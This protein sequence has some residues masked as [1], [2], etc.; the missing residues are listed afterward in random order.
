MRTVVYA[1]ILA[2][3]CYAPTIV[4]GTPCDI[5]CPTGL[6]CIDHICREPGYVADAPLP[7]DSPGLPTDGPAPDGPADLDGDGVLNAADNCPTTANVDQHDEDGDTLGDSCDPC[8]HLPGTA[9][10]S[11]GDGVGDA[12]DPQ[13]TIAKQ[14][15]VMFDPFTTQRAV[16]DFS[17]GTTLIA[18]QMKMVGTSANSGFSRLSNQT[19]GELRIISGGTIASVA[20]TTPHALSIAFGVNSTG[21]NYHYVQFYDSGVGTGEISISRAQG[22]SFPSL[23]STS[24]PGTLPTGA[25]SL[26]IDE[27][28]SGGMIALTSRLGGTLH[29]AFSTAAPAHTT[30]TGVSVLVRNADVRFDY[31]GIIATIP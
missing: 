6:S 17:T 12:C 15:W 2:S 20:G 26:Q 22:A 7:I 21:A 25:W 31:F 23:A 3:G 4:P 24:Y 5:A 16:W 29:P 8:P 19:T 1:V 10:D 11:D 13:P 28:V 18:D 14:I 9:S 30:G 27:T